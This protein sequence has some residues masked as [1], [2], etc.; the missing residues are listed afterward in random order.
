MSSTEIDSFNDLVVNTTYYEDPECE[1]L[2]GKFVRKDFDNTNGKETWVFEKDGK[3]KIYEMK[4]L[5]GHRSLFSKASGGKRRKMKS[6]KKRS[7]KKRSNKKR[8]TVRK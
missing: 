4:D 5:A 3:E 7:N 1:E 8:R 6:N 2:F